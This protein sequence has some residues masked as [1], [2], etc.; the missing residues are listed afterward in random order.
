M[1]QW[2]IARNGQQEGPVT[3][4]QIGALVQAGTLDPA[5]TLVWREGLTDWKPLAESG[6]LAESA[7]VAPVTTKPA[8]DNPYLV[9]ERTRVTL[10]ETR[11]DM[12]VEYPGYGRLRYFLTT[13]VFVIISYAILIA[14]VFAMFG[15]KGS[16]GG[17]AAG[18]LVIILLMVV[19]SVYIALQRLKNLGMSGWAILWTLVPIM[20]L[21]ISW[22]MIA[23]AAGYED[24]RT[25]DTAAKVITGL[26]LGMVGLSIAANILVAVMGGHS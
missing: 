21:W 1:D 20:N 24:H 3:A 10:E 12:P 16:A 13:T 8:S 9:T 6:V 22:R 17:V 14:L 19:G 25:M 7:A 15:S 2:Y 26:W 5:S 4:P 18:T 23:C 11:R